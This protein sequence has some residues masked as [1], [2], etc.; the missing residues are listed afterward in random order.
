MQT[1]NN[2]FED[3]FSATDLSN[4]QTLVV[5]IEGNDS[6]G[7]YTYAFDDEYNCVLQA[8]WSH[9]PTRQEVCSLFNLEY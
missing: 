8:T 5:Q 9:K 7:F 6:Q 2:Y 1:A 4:D 3:T